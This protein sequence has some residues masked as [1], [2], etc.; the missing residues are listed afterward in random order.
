MDLTLYDKIGPEKLRKLIH[1]F[2][3]EIRQDELL[4]PMYQGD[5]EGAEERLYLFIIQYFGGPD[6]YNQQR[7]HPR[8]RQR[9]I[10]FPITEEAK[11]HWLK[12]ME[13]AFELSEIGKAEKELMWEY[14]QQTAEFLKNR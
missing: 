3:L 4:K 9:H 14:F 13:H 2:Y 1:D 10:L 6:Y 12:N 7:G 5:F 11:Q 8:L